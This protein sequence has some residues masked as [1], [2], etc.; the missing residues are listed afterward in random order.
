MSRG[1][2]Q[3]TNGG[4]LNHVHPYKA[5][6]TELEMRCLLLELSWRLCLI[7]RL[8]LR[9]WCKMRH[10]E[11]LDAF[12]KRKNEATFIMPEARDE[13]YTQFMEKTARIQESSLGQRR[14]FYQWRI[15]CHSLITEIKTN[16]QI[17][18]L[19]SL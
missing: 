13:F 5:A 14:S 10:F 2:G 1:P 15:N 6:F 3:E 11:D 7:E 17:K 4:M 9:K 18:L 16:S 12:K 8:L 19:S